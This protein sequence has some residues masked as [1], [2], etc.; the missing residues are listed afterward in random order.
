MQNSQLILGQ[1]YMVKHIG[2][3]KAVRRIYRGEESGV[4][5]IKRFVFSAKVRKGVFAIVEEQTNENGD[6]TGVCFYHWK[7][8]RKV[9]RQEISIPY[10][11][12]KQV[13]IIKN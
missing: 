10:Y 6:K 3:I 1:P 5:N 4:L 8:T 2:G 7:N 12:L 11:D 13:S 9:P